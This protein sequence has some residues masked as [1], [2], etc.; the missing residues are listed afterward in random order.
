MEG[1]RKASGKAMD[2]SLPGRVSDG[3]AGDSGAFPVRRKAMRAGGR[4]PCLL[5]K[6][7]GFQIYLKGIVKCGGINGN[8]CRNIPL[9]FLFFQAAWSNGFPSASRSALLHTAPKGDAAAVA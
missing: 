5:S 4:K 8:R 9:F 3:C 1:I 2:S 6:G 7:R